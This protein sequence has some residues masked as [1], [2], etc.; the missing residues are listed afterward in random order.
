MTVKPMP[1]KRDRVLLEFDPPQ[2]PFD[3]SGEVYALSGI[4]KGDEIT[5]EKLA[6]LREE[7]ARVGCRR[8]A[9]SLIALK[10]RSRSELA[11]ALA[12]RKFAKH[13]IQETLEDLE[14]KGYLDDTE[15]ARQAIEQAI[16]SGKAGPN[17]LRQQ[18]AAKGVA[19]EI[20][21]REL[22]P[23]RD[24]ETQERAATALLVK[25]NKRAKPDDPQKRRMAA[26]GYLARRGFD[27][28]LVW[29][30]VRSVIDAPDD[31]ESD[32]PQ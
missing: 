22:E 30:V 13:V 4:A 9:W 14:A 18:L 23:L 32:S 27:S 5:A 12:Q 10:S 25:W 28:G 6:E 29:E 21:E 11:R 3:L 20:A 26:A 2:E 15:F 1:R 7:D 8:K 19:R 17:L 24:R 31:W 16:T